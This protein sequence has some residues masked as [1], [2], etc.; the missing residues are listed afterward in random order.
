MKT[1]ELIKNIA[2][3]LFNVKG[4]KNV[5]LREIASEIN[6]SYGNVTYHFSTKEE[7]LVMLFD[8][9]NESLLELQNSDMLIEN[10]LHY[11]LIVPDFSFDITVKYLFLFVD[12][13]EIKR[14]YPKFISQVELKNIERKQKW[15]GLLIELQKQKFLKSELSESD[16]DFIMELSIG[17]RMYY[18][19]ETPLVSLNKSEFSFKVNRLLFPYLSNIGKE[20]YVD[21]YS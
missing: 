12:Y 17:L 6:K 4:I 15:K 7:L 21:F 11:F 18:F 20:F 8:D 10:I 9:Y 19:Q 13:T 14:S 5:T 16:I 1:K 2:I 3:E